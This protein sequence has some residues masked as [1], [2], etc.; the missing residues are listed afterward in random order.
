MGRPT[1]KDLREMFQSELK[2]KESQI[3]EI[4]CNWCAG[5]CFHKASST[6]GFNRGMLNERVN[7]GARQ[8][9]FSLCEGCLLKLFTVF[10]IKPEKIT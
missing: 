6:S 10:A 2:H 8:Y 7:V 3:S 4:A 9:K 5:S 1:L